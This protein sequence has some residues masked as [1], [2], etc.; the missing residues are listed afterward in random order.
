L[1]ELVPYPDEPPLPEP[2]YPPEP[3]HRDDP[4]AW[5]RF[6]SRAGEAFTPFADR[7]NQIAVFDRIIDECGDSS[8]HGVR[9]G[10]AAVMIMKASRVIDRERLAALYDEI[11]MRARSMP[12]PASGS[13]DLWAR[14]GKAVLQERRIDRQ[15]MLDDLLEKKR[16]GET[17][18]LRNLVLRAQL[19]RTREEDERPRRIERCAALLADIAKNH[20]L[21][22]VAV[23]KVLNEALAVRLADT[24][25]MAEIIAACDETL[26]RNAE[27]KILKVA[28]IKAMVVKVPMEALPNPKY[29]AHDDEREAIGRYLIERFGADADPDVEAA[30]V[31]GLERAYGWYRQPSGVVALYDGAVAFAETKGLASALPKL[32][33]IR[34][35]FI[36]GSVIAPIA[37]VR[38]SKFKMKRKVVPSIDMALARGLLMQANATDDP[39]SAR[40]QYD[41]IIASYQGSPDARGRMMAVEAYLYRIALAPE[42]QERLVLCDRAIATFGGDK[43]VREKSAYS[44]SFLRSVLE[45]KS[46]LL[47]D[48]SPFIDHYDRVAAE[49]VDA[50]AVAEAKYE[51]TRFLRDKKDK[52]VIFDELITLLEGE[53]RPEAMRIVAECLRQKADDGIFSVASAEE[54]APFYYRIIGMHYC[55]PDRSL[56]LEAK[57]ALRRLI[58]SK[59]SAEPG[60]TP[61]QM[62]KDDNEQ[63]RLRAMLVDDAQDE[64]ELA[65][66]LDSLKLYAR[67]D[68]ERRA[69]TAW[70]DEHVQGKRKSV[71][72][73]SPY[74]ALYDKRGREHKSNAFYDVVINDYLAGKKDVM[75]EHFTWA[76]LGKTELADTPEEKLRIWDEY[77][78]HIGPKPREADLLRKAELLDLVGRDSLPV[79]EEIID[80]NRRLRRDRVPFETFLALNGKYKLLETREEQLAILD[81]IIAL[82]R[83][84][85]SDKFEHSSRRSCFGE[86]HKSA[87][88][89]KSEL[90]DDA[91]IKREYFQ[92][93]IGWFQASKEWNARQYVEEALK[94]LAKKGDQRE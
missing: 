41:Q 17:P 80:R 46:V 47:L 12:Y 21:E 81:E 19:F 14:T 6:L 93:V 91:S 1:H 11:I 43:D 29:Y 23:R 51:K 44:G 63:K 65:S 61:K 92:E 2:A 59:K 64:L 85:D 25:N 42:P 54:R 78:E 83:S 66:A 76:Y 88:V 34:M 79:Y 36:A 50:L 53:Y 75:P 7:Y 24:R 74:D 15:R 82:C 71:I 16:N 27:S 38:F 67:N 48:K 62:K 8:D 37:Q 20:D 49:S 69:L 77:L 58:S 4:V 13:A 70:M 84:A 28:V 39:D 90:L 5:T 86:E 89:R 26:S 55:S 22:D 87:I 60:R 31:A 18:E 45:C 68:E 35:D 52:I 32:Q 30:Y 40:T 10:V 3:P 73:S 72:K 33:L 57:D 9:G 94:E 56:R